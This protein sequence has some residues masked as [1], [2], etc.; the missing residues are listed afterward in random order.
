VQ[1]SSTVCA[2]QL[3]CT[4]TAGAQ[5]GWVGGFQM[6]VMEGLQGDRHYVICLINATGG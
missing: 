5:Q 2:D 4:C 6:E 1:L 3:L